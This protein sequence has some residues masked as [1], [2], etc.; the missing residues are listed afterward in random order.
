MN[1]EILDNPYEFKKFKQIYHDSDYR[2]TDMGWWNKKVKF[3]LFSFELKIG[4][5]CWILLKG[6]YTN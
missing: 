1:T 2:V 3:F 5:I 4:L 6:P